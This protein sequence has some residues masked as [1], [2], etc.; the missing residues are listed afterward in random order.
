M[1]PR[2]TRWREERGERREER[3][4]RPGKESVVRCKCDDQELNRDTIPIPTLLRIS[5]R[6]PAVNLDQTLKASFALLTA[7]SLC[8]ISI[9]SIS[10][11]PQPSPD[12][13]R[14]LSL[15]P[16]TVDTTCPDLGCLTS[17]GWP[18]RSC[19]PLMR[20]GMEGMVV[21][22]VELVVDKLRCSPANTDL[23]EANMV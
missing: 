15:A 12:T 1:R 20:V 17:K 19:L 23:R 7:S 13:H 16:Y 22:R 3:G 21:E 4:E 11:D 18:D 8:Q 6:F 9:N 10:R 5:L 2:R 14:S